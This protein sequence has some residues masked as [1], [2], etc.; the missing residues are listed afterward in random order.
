[1]KYFLK[2]HHGIAFLVISFLI[3]EMIYLLWCRYYGTQIKGELFFKIILNGTIVTMLFQILIG[4]F[5]MNFYFF[6]FKNEINIIK[7]LKQE[8]IRLKLIEHPIMMMIGFFIFVLFT[9]NFFKK[10]KLLTRFYFYFFY[11]Y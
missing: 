6:S 10:N 3:V 11:L 2:F 1:M 5:L 9:I 7:I 4:L 8:K